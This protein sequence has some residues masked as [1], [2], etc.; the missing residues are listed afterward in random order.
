[1]KGGGGG[2]GGTLIIQRRTPNFEYRMIRLLDIRFEM[3]PLV[4]DGVFVS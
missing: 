3:G 4:R 1:M 2:G